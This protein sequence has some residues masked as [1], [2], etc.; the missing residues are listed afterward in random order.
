MDAA[1]AHSAEPSHDYPRPIHLDGGYA[2]RTG[3]AKVRARRYRDAGAGAAGSGVDRRANRQGPAAMSRR[4][5][6]LCTVS[7]PHPH[8][9]QHTCVGGSALEVSLCGRGAI[10]VEGV[11]RPQAGFSETAITDEC[12]ARER[13]EGG[14]LGAPTPVLRSPPPCSSSVSASTRIGDSGVDSNE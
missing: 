1:A 6:R 13:Q 2:R 8:L 14:L 12:F 10:P 9:L 4:T 7:R 11:E 3:K 5:L